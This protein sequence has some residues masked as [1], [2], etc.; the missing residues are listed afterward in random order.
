MDYSMSEMFLA[1]AVSAAICSGLLGLLARTLPANFL[2]A[3]QNSRSNH[4]LPARQIGGLA[5]IPAIILAAFLFGDHLTTDIRLLYSLTAATLLLWVVGFLD[6]RIELP[7]APRILAQMLAALLGAYGLGTEVRLLPEFVP[8]AVEFVLIALGLLTCINITNF[9]DGLDWLTVSGLGLP[10]VGAAVLAL[11]GL[12][13]IESGGIAAILAGALAG[14]AYFNKPPARIFLGDSGS[15]P[16]GLL[17]ATAFILLARQTSIVVAGLLPLYYLMDA[18]TTLVMRARNGENIL[19]A[20][21]QHAYQVA[22]RSGRSVLNIVGSIARLNLFLLA[23]A[24]GFNS[25]IA[26]VWQTLFALLGIT[27]TAWQLIAFRKTANKQS[28]DA[29]P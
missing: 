16:L 8:A 21:S 23:C 20:H 18:G 11:L 24:I 19:A 14:F 9:M 25:S 5:V 13:G 12:S 29:Q 15:L 28:T 17:S 1:F 6:D 3:Q 27:A 26:A 7:I 2:A 10:L 4:T 22:R